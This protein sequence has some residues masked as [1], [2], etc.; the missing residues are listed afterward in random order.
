M[1]LSLSSALAI[2]AI[3]GGAL[4]FAGAPKAHANLLVN[5]GFEDG[6]FNGWTQGDNTGFTGV[7]G[8][9]SGVNPEEGN[10]QAFFG[11]VGSTGFIT[12]TFA[13]TAGQSYE[14]SL[15]MYNFGGT[16]SSFNASLDSTSFVN[17][18]DSSAQPYTNYTLQF[19][20]TGSDTV[21]ITAR[22]DP[23]YWLVDN[24]QVN[25]VSGVPEPSTWAMMI[26]GFVGLGFLAYRRKHKLTLSAA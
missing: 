4:F 8:N 17:L 23:S 24:V 7:Q 20:G 2:A 19:T 25:Q 5:G 6:N 11:P 12:Q 3:S 1:K 22:Q 13:D 16:P 9:F 14:V 18:T 26:L 21:T 15:W 10:D